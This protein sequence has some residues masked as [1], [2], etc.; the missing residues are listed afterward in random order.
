MKSKEGSAKEEK[1]ALTSELQA[2]TKEKTKLEFTLKDL[3]DE[4]AGDSNSKV[5]CSSS[6]TCI[7]MFWLR[8]GGYT[9]RSSILA[10][11]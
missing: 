9:E 10:D 1:D 7:A 8:P 4:V 5:G 11:Q 3:R 2:Q 6:K